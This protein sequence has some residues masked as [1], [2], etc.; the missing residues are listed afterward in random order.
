M[1]KEKRGAALKRSMTNDVRIANA[2]KLERPTEPP[3]LPPEIYHSGPPMIAI[4]PVRLRVPVSPYDAA[5]MR[6]EIRRHRV[7]GETAGIM[8]FTD[9]LDY[10]ELYERFKS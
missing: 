8:T 6:E 7:N 3:S 5:L 10:L 1:V 2:K 9:F 4:P